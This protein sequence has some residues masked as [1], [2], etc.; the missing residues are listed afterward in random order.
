M[1]VACGEQY[2]MSTV[3]LVNS[4]HEQTTFADSRGAYRC[5]N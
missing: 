5:E 1:P 3:A 4:V 2:C